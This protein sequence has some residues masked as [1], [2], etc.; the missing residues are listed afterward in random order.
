MT[1]ARVLTA[2]LGLL[3]CGGAKPVQSQ[4]CR[5]YITCYEKVGGTGPTIDTYGPNGS[6]WRMPATAQSCTAACTSTL[7]MLKAAYPNAGCE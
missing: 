4:V 6:C 1:K 5:D 2:V 3:G 7:G